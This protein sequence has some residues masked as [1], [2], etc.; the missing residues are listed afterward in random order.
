MTPDQAVPGD[1][2]MPVASAYDN[3]ELKW[4]VPAKL[5]NR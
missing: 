2:R 4:L 5:V 3:K 1:P